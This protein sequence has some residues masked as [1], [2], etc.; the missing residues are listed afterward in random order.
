M[1]T[2]VENGKAFEWAVATELANQIGVAV[3]D[4]DVSRFAVACF[5]KI[6]P[7]L[8]ARFTVAA[9]LSV[10]HILQ[11]EARHP[12]VLAPLR[13]VILPDGRG[14]SGDVRDVVLEAAGSNLGISCKSNHAAFKHSRLSARLDFVR[15]WGLDPAGVSPAYR[16]AIAP[17]FD[18]L[19]LLRQNSHATARWHD[20]PD[21]MGDVY[22]PILDAFT[23]ELNRVAGQNSADSVKCANALLTYFI[24]NHDFYKVIA[25][26][27]QV[28]IQAFNFSGTLSGKKSRPASQ[29]VQIDPTTERNARTLRIDRFIFHMRIHSASSRIEASLKFD[30]QAHSLPAENIYTQVISY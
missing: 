13:V 25:R 1:A 23:T 28:L 2:Q 18:E 26:S 10:A 5:G 27:D 11:R 21:V 12:T 24:G 15:R 6:T 30:I 9:R 22:A 16:E 7:A 8:R 19:K 4:D 3:A 29:G 20:L 14:Q 17:I